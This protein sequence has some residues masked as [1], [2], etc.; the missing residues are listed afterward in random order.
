MLVSKLT[1]LGGVWQVGSIASCIDDDG[2][3]SEAWRSRESKVR[4]EDKQWMDVR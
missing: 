1:G 4:R 2:A 3:S